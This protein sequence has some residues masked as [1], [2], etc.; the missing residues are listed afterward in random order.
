ML[1]GT[2]YDGIV[3][4]TDAALVF[5]KLSVTAAFDL[6]PPESQAPIP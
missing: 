3:S 4:Q 2:G 1:F 5:W 6:L